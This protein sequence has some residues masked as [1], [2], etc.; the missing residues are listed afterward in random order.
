MKELE[1]LL[2][3]GLIVEERVSKSY[4]KYFVCKPKSELEKLAKNNTNDYGYYFIT[5]DSPIELGDVVSY[6]YFING[7]WI[8]E[9]WECVPG[10][11]T[12]DFVCE[13]D[14]LQS[15]VGS[16][17][18]FYFGK[19]T[20]INGWLFPLHKH[21]ELN[22]NNI[23]VV[24][25]DLVNIDEG[26]FYRIAR[27]RWEFTERLRSMSRWKKALQHQFIVISH[28]EQ[29]DVFLALR[30]DMQEFYIVHKH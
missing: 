15:A 13:F 25:R 14:N 29:V 26:T 23:P 2:K 20:L 18:N 1:K 9:V 10:P 30:R 5:L 6:L 27:K 17:I 11:A 24:L 16:V 21:P 19:P 12:D 22:I 28:I 8:F 3:L 7:K 4:K